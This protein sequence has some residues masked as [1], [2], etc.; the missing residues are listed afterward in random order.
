M[1]YGA[2]V[3][4]FEALGRLWLKNSEKKHNE[5]LMDIFMN[6]SRNFPTYKPSFWK[7]WTWIKLPRRDRSIN[8]SLRENGY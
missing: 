3:P 1:H 5:V 7:N 4:D 6:T 2:M 8:R